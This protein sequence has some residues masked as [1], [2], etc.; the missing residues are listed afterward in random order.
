MTARRSVVPVAASRSRFKTR[1]Q[2]SRGPI[3][4]WKIR[5]RPLF[6][7][8]TRLTL[9]PAKRAAVTIN[10]VSVFSGLTDLIPKTRMTDL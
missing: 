2:T 8:Q 7:S 1:H 9:K 6:H 10:S 3:D 5:V 4:R